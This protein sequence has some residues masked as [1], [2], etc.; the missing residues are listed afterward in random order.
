M[1]EYSFRGTRKVAAVALS[2]ALICSAASLAE[3]TGIEDNCT[4]VITVS[5]AENETPESSFQYEENNNGEIVITGFTGSETQVSIPSQINGR[6]VA[7]IG[8]YAF[9]GC[10]G[11]NKISI[12]EN[13]E[14]IGKK[15]FDSD[16]NVTIYG[17]PGSY[18]QTYAQQNN[19][20]FSEMLPELENKC[21]V[22]KTSFTVG[23]T[24]TVTGDAAG[25]SG[26]YTYEFYYKR[27]NAADWTRFGS[28]SSARFAPSSAGSFVIRTYVKDSTGKAVRKEFSLTAA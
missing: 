8:D 27:T 7:H 23:E 24:V 26:A 16:K 12:P 19:I 22:S 20:P 3:M 9:S 1:D 14:K 10:I 18:V 5:A 13:V 25:G 2:A 6:T 11:L 21:T 4:G 15:V 28:G 17:V